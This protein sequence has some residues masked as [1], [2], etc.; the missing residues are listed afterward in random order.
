MIQIQCLWATLMLVQ[1]THQHSP[2]VLDLNH[3]SSNKAY[4]CI[5]LFI[6]DRKN[7]IICWNSL[8]IIDKNGFKMPLIVKKIN[9]FIQGK[10]WTSR[11]DNHAPSCTKSTSHSVGAVCGVYYTF[12]IHSAYS[13]KTQ[14]E[15]KKSSWSVWMSV[16][17]V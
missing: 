11:C 3:F 10:K 17:L 14:S 2:Q 8:R 12:S 1:C 15:N 13:L 16:I 6:H 7:K 5:D 4:A 9:Y